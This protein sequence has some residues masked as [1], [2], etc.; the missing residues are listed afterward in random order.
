MLLTLV[1][2]QLR[3]SRTSVLTVYPLRQLRDNWRSC[4]V[5]QETRN[6]RIDY[7]RFPD[8]GIASVV[9]TGAGHGGVEIGIMGWEGMTGLA[10]VIGGRAF[11]P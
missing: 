2:Q 5:G 10:V 1:F 3:M 11:T 6:R 9:S 7:V 8:C 4:P